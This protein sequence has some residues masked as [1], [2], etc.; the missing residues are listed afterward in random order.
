M[1]T[2]LNGDPEIAPLRTSLYPAQE[3]A[4]DSFV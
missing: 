3:S 4:I 1:S 2:Q